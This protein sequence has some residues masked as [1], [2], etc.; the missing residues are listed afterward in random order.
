MHNAHS[1]IIG[2]IGPLVSEND[3]VQS[4]TECSEKVGPVKF[5]ATRLKRSAQLQ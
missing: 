5:T 1:I 4:Q 2:D 3:S